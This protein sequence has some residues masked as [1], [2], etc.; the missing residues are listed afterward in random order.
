MTSESCLSLA[1]DVA[2]GVPADTIF[3]LTSVSPTMT[4]VVAQQACIHTWVAAGLRVKTFNHTSEVEAIR[5]RLDV[6]VVPVPDCATSATEFGKRY[7]TIKAMLD[8]AAERNAP[9]MLINADIELRLEPWEL[10]RARWLSDGGLCYVIRHNHDG[11]ARSAARERYGIDA[12]LLHGRD[13]SLFPPSHLSMGVPFWDYWLPHTFLKHD[14]PIRSIE[15][16]VAFHRNHP[17]QWTRDSWHRG[18]REFARV[19]GTLGKDQSYE[20][21]SQMAGAVRQSF[22]RWKVPLLQ[23]PTGINAWVQRR[24]RMRGSKTFIQIGSHEGR[25]TDW[26]AAL[27]DVTVHAFEPDPRNRQR[28][29]SNVVEIRA[30]IAASD[31][32]SSFVLSERGWDR[33]WTQSSSLR[34]PK[35]HLS[36]Y[37]VTF[38]DV[39]G[40]PTMALDTYAA[41]KG[42]T[43]VDLVWAE[44]QGA[45]GDMIAGGG[46]TLSNTR[47]LY[48]QYSDG[49][50]YEG[51]VT[52]GEILA[53]LPEF[54]V[55]ELWPEYVLLENRSLA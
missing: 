25:D 29:R 31:G 30:A 2:A 26:M 17:I 52:L 55:V 9:A 7:V 8:W 38:G 45:E 24:F 16:P 27:P 11:D 21:C 23:H 40:V 4:D 42:L 32:H 47:Y 35:N 36:R 14:R 37:P 50:M 48:T 28:P 46:N 5:R 34:R 18:A 12:F 51:Q 53:R 41:S 49:E 43:T 39:I 54:R 33:E 3:A 15:Y 22:D 6:D 19:T 1:N 44:V 20:V 10:Q 13:A